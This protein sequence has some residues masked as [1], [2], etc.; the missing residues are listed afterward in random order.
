M[1]VC[2]CT[3]VCVACVLHL[4]NAKPRKHILMAVMLVNSTVEVIL[5]VAATHYAICYFR[6]LNVCLHPFPSS[7]ASNWSE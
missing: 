1:N 5:H 2:L 7:G 3:F 4:S 6:Y